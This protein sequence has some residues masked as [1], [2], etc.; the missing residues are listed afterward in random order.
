MFTKISTIPWSTDL[1]DLGMMLIKML[2]R[3][4]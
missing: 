2:S 1:A 3:S 4:E